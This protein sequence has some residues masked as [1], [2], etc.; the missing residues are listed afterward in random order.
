MKAQRCPVCGGS[1]K[2][3]VPNTESTAGPQY[4]PCHGCGGKGWVEVSEASPVDYPIR[5]IYPA[6]PPWPT[7][8]P[9]HPNEPII[10]YYTCGSGAA[11]KA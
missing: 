5:P 6:Y 9:W 10:T 7:P 4:Q 11:A 3:Q 8:W 2:Y 1:G